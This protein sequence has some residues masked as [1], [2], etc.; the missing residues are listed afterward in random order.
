M[1]SNNL[2]VVDGQEPIPMSMPS[3]AID[4]SA[5][6]KQPSLLAAVKYCISCS[7]IDDDK[8]IYMTLAIDPGHW[9]RILKGDAHFPLNKLGALM[10]FCGNEAPLI[11][12]A[13]VRGYELQKKESEI[14]LELKR[15][16]KARE[17]AENRAA[18]LEELFTKRA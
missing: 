8:Q 16:R 7:G 18:I 13:D 17:E 5:V 15:E 14:E 12:L 4:N 10:D 1:K 3:Q 6:F 11:W 2:S 9:S